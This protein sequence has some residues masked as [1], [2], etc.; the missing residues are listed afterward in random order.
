M[1][2]Q[3]SIRPPQKVVQPRSP[4]HPPLWMSRCFP[5]YS[6]L[7][8]CPTQVWV[9]TVMN[10]YYW[11]NRFAYAGWRAPQV[12]PIG[13]LIRQ[14]W[15]KKMQSKMAYVHQIFILSNHKSR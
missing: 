9:G 12:L 4:G 3:K 5:V 6:S 2:K 10:P 8:C 11:P 13:M 1:R 15:P 7:M 14:T